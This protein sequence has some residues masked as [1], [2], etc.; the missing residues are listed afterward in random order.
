M[1]ET[2]LTL[3][4]AIDQVIEALNSFEDKDRKAIL[5]TVCAH[6]QIDIGTPATAAAHAHSS[7]ATPPVAQSEPSSNAGHDRRADL[8]LDIKGL[9]TQKNPS[10]ARQMAC[11]VAYYLLD[12]APQAERKNTI[13]TTYLEKYFK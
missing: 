10:S 7:K 11:I 2:K 12:H 4:R 1:A 9:K 3:G 13:T 8:G 5:S 6:L